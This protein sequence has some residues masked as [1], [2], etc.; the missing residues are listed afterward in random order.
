MVECGV[1]LNHVLLSCKRLT[2]SFPFLAMKLTL[3]KFLVAAVL[4]VIVA[5]ASFEVVDAGAG[6][7]FGTREFGALANATITFVYGVRAV[8]DTVTA[9][10]GR[11]ASSIVAT[12]CAL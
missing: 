5:V 11:L 1:N 10:L 6:A 2:N 3:T 9:V 12:E 4:A 7:V 8:D